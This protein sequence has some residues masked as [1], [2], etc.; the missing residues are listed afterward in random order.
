MTT[1][2][3]CLSAW[4]PTR[5]TDWL[6]QGP[7]CTGRQGQF[8]QA[9]LCWTLAI[10]IRPPE[11]K[12]RNTWAV[13]LFHSS[14]LFL[15]NWWSEIWGPHYFTNKGESLF[16]NYPSNTETFCDSGNILFLG[17]KYNLITEHLVKIGHALCKHSSWKFLNEWSYILHSC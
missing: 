12:V 17:L 14:S 2:H 3:L 5:G 11:A 1:S 4:L 8:F 13:T 7:P 6:A 15:S 10:V 9:H 16:S